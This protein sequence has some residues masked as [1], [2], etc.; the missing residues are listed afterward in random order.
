MSASVQIIV[1]LGLQGTTTSRM[2]SRFL[3]RLDAAPFP[4][5]PP[6]FLRL[7]A[8]SFLSGL[9]IRPSSRH[10]ASVFQ[11]IHHPA[12]RVSF[13]ADAFNQTPSTC[14][15]QNASPGKA[16]LLAPDRDIQDVRGHV[17]GAGETRE[18]FAKPHVLYTT[19]G[20]L[21]TLPQL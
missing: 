12:V 18:I 11:L 10:L 6:A 7:E 2:D 13:L 21:R 3:L 9:L 17:M 5:N 20:S 1:F 19:E 16:V 8:S 4:L 14:G 15:S